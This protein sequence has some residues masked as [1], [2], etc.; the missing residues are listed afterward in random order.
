[1]LQVRAPKALYMFHDVSGHR[2]HDVDKAAAGGD[3]HGEDNNTS[4]GAAGSYPRLEDLQ[5]GAAEDQER[6]V[7]RPGEQDHRWSTDLLVP[8]WS[9]RARWLSRGWVAWVNAVTAI[10]PDDDEVA[11]A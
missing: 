6:Q 5:E 4:S 8:A 1:M 3:D 11:A 2:E 10:C 9:W 7:Q